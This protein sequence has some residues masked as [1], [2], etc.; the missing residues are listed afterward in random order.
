MVSST[1]KW[2]KD[3]IEFNDKDLKSISPGCVYRANLKNV[4]PD[5]ETYKS[6]KDV[7][8]IALI[9]E[10]NDELADLND[11]EWEKTKLTHSQINADKESAGLKT[12]VKKFSGIA[13]RHVRGK[14]TKQYRGLLT[15][16]PN[17]RKKL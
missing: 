15:I 2:T 17:I 14:V 1:C 3:V 13:A 12:S 6:Y 11:D 8:P 16:Y 7:L 4:Y 9:S 10:P 5:N